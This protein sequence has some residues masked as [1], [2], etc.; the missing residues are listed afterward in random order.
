MAIVCVLM[1]QVFP[2]YPASALKASSDSPE[3]T[4]KRRNHRPCCP[5]LSKVRSHLIQLLGTDHPLKEASRMSFRTRVL[6][7]FLVTLALL[8]AFALPA[9][10]AQP[11][12]QP[13][14]DITEVPTAAQPGPAF[15]A[16]A[17][18]QAYLEMIPPAA[19]ARSDAYF[20]GGYW[21]VLW[22][23][24][25]ASAIYLILLQT[26]LSAKMRDFAV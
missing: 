26:G 22:D 2:R 6:S 17:A 15:N 4:A 12:I 13:T 18:T 5:V 10:Q 3:Y 19:K 7:R 24:L 8:A 20:E 1:S 21:L 11:P 16:D 9:L 25:Y 23:F 14:V